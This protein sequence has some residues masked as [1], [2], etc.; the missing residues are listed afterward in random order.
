MSSVRWAVALF[1]IGA[2]SADTSATTGV[3]DVA[4]SDSVTT[5]RVAVAI[6]TRYESVYD[7]R[8]AVEE[9]GFQCSDWEVVSEPIGAVERATC[10]SA[11]VFSIYA[12]ASQARSSIDIARDLIVSLGRDSVFLV[13]PNWSVN[14]S[15]DLVRCEEFLTALGG[16]L[17]VKQAD[18]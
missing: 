11:V 3:E 13:G 14:C 17:D 16:E 4:T 7:I 2:C 8:V 9:S 15:D 1:L 6:N 5:T 18:S 10:T 12:D